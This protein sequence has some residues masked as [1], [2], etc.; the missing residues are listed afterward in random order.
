[1]GSADENQWREK[2]KSKH[3]QPY[4]APNEL[5]ISRAVPATMA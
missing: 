3:F 2:E 5:I 1:M 4:K